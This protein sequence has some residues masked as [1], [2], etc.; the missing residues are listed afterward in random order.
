MRQDCGGCSEAGVSAVRDLVARR[1][2]SDALRRLLGELLGDN[3]G[4]GGNISLEYLCGE[5]LAN[6]AG[7]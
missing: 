1:D 4:D 2:E 5:T 3:G 7:K 6:E